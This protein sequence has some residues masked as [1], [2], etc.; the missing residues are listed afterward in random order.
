[1]K[2]ILSVFLVL[3]CL[4]IFCA[5]GSD[6]GGSD[7]LNPHFTGEVIEKYEKSCLVKVADIGNGHLAVGD[8]VVV[9]TNIRDCPEYAVGDFL[10]IVFDGKIAESYPPQILNVSIISKVEVE[11]NVS[12]AS[13]QHT[14]S[15]AANNVSDP[16]IILLKQKYSQYF[17]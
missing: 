9:S 10:K 3:I 14:S 17:D 1:M 2:K 6:D 8:E 4:M 13:Q 7:I 5:C 11:G 16:E 12:D 15:D